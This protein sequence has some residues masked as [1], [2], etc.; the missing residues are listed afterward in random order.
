MLD[1]FDFIRG[2]GAWRQMSG[3]LAFL[4]ALLGG[5]L[6]LLFSVVGVTSLATAESWSSSSLPALAGA[7]IGLWLLGS[8]IR[9]VRAFF[10]ADSEQG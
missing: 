9:G 2:P 7:L 3:P 8:V 6:G 1:L 5:L 4:T 10:R